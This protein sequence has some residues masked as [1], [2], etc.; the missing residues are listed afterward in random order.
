MTMKL[1]PSKMSVAEVNA[2]KEQ[3][4]G[5]EPVAANQDGVQ[6]APEN[7]QAIQAMLNRNRAKLARDE[8]LIAKGRQKDKIAS[9]A[10]RLEEEIVKNRPTQKMMEA[11]PGTTEFNRAVQANIAFQRQ[12]K[13]AMM[14]LKD[15][16]RR[17]EPDNP[18][19]GNLENVR[20]T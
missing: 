12:F 5:W 19:A 13:P 15:L 3:I 14:R 10:R 20:S 8:A 2:I 6:R 17:L 7:P 1:G 4:R 11:K 9:E 18:N 16:K